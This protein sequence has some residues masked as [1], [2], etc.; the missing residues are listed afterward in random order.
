MCVRG[1]AVEGQSAGLM[2]YIH[3]YSLTGGGRSRDIGA[4]LVVTDRVSVIRAEQLP[5][6]FI[7]SHEYGV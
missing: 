6:L 1:D 4:L 2:V 5:G 3:S 7:L